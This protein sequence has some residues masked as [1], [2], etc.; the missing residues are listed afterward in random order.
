MLISRTIRGRLPKLILPNNQCLSLLSQKYQNFSLYTID[1]NVFGL[2]E[3][4]KQLRATIHNFCQKELAPHADAIDKQNDFPQIREFWKKLGD[5]GLLG[6]VASSEYGG[7]EMGYLDLCIVNEEMTRA[8]AAIALSY[9]ASAYLCVNRIND[10]GTHEQKQKYLPKLCSG[11]YIGALAM[12]EA[13]SGSDV[14]SMSTKAEKHGDYWILNGS[15]FWITNGPDADVIVVYAK[16]NPNADNPAHGITAFIVEKGMDGFSTGPKLDKL[17]LRGSNTGELIFQDCKVPASNVLGSVNKG[18]YV[19]FSGLDLERLVLASS[20]VGLMQAACDVAWDYAHQR[21]QFGCRIGEF[22]M[23]QS[24]MAD[25]YTALSTS[26]CY[27]YS[28]AKACDKGHY[29]GKDCAGVILY[30]AENATKV[31]LDAIQIL[32]GNGYSNCYPTGRFLRDAKLY[33]I[34][35][36]TS[37]VRRLIIGRALNKEYN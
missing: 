25:M 23:I 32:G 36:G 27:V 6:I 15:K 24:K 12:S 31:A 22:Q 11:E 13:G 4:Q 34:G 37:E 35:A 30:C 1:D 14:V 8:S 20:P 19:L 16:T 17:G 10:C 21:K 3:D 26:R 28:V 7:T 18:I 29:N 2:N 5:L 9:G 33:E